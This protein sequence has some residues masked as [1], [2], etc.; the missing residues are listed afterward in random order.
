M[1]GQDASDGGVRGRWRAELRL[2]GGPRDQAEEGQ[3]AARLGRC[4]LL[5]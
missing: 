2:S 4:W 5:G 3:R 1:W